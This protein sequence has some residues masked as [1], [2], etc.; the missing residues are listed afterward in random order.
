MY[1]LLFLSSDTGKSIDMIGIERIFKNYMLIIIC[2]IGLKTHAN[3]VTIGV[4]I[5]TIGF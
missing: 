5:V 1:H 3:F 2:Q 4:K